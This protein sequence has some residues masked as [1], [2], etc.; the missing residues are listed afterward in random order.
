MKKKIVL[1]PNWKDA[2]R[3]GSVRWSGVGFFVMGFI[4][5]FHDLVRQLPAE[6]SSKIP[7][8]STIAMVLFILVMISR[9][10]KRVH[11]KDDEDGE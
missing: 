2:W 3:F 8:A 5:F 10:L 7:R 4:E 11:K 1:I 9:I 6:I